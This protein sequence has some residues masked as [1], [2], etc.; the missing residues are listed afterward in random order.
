MHYNILTLPEF[1]K[2]V[3]KLSKRY[4]NIKNDLTKLTNDLQSDS[5]LGIH[6]FGMCYKIRLANSSVPTGKSKGFRVI[7]YYMD[8][9]DTL[10]LLN[11]YSKSD[12]DTISD[13][14]IIEL[15][16]QVK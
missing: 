9:S 8:K 4:K 7:I 5:D 2:N 3:K 11:I 16:K 12:K 6:L 10:Y 14:E 1:D 15:L 13:S